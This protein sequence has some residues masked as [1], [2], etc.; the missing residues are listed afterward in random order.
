MHGSYGA[1]FRIYKKNW[2]AIGGLYAEEKAGAIGDGGIAAAR[3]VRQCFDF[4]ND[5]GMKLSERGQREVVCATR[6]LEAAAVL[7]DVFAG[8]PIGETKIE[9]FFSVEV[10]VA[11]GASAETVHQPGEFRKGSD[12]KDSNAADSVLAPM[13]GASFRAAR[14]ACCTTRFKCLGGSH[15]PNSIIGAG[16]GSEHACGGVVREPPRSRSYH[17]M[18]AESWQDG[19]T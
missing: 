4:M 12:F 13:A 14:L 9:H 1:V 15:N 3:Q 5:V 11:A 6:G 18:L 16:C 2:H 17:E 19:D 8:V 7:Q 10:A